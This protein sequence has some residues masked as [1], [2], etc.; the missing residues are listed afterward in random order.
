MQFLTIFYFFAGV[1]ISITSVVLVD[2]LGLENLTN[3]FGLTLLFQGIATLL[4]PP[5]AGKQT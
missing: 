1:Y 2:L 4:G 5:A 3:S